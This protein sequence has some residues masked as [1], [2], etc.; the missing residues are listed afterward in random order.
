MKSPVE[1]IVRWVEWI[2]PYGPNN[3]PVFCRV[4]E[5]TAVACAKALAARDSH[6]YEDDERALENFMVVHWAYFV[7]PPEKCAPC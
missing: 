6:T 7:I 4:S 1:N 3:E 2:D 5:T